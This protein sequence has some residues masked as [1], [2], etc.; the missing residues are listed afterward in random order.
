MG[1]QES[2]EEKVISEALNKAGKVNPY[3]KVANIA[4]KVTG[5]KVAEVGARAIPKVPNMP[6]SFLDNNKIKDLEKDELEKQDELENQDGLENQQNNSRYDLKSMFKNRLKSKFSKGKNKTEEENGLSDAINKFK[7]AERIGTI[8]LSITPILLGVF[9]TIIVVIIVLSPLFH[10]KEFKSNTK[11]KFVNF[12]TF[13]GFVT[14]QELIDEFYNEINS[15]SLNAQDKFMVDIDEELLEATLLYG[16]YDI[17]DYFNLLNKYETNNGV[18]SDEEGINYK[19]LTKEVYFTSRNMMY[20]SSSITNEI[21]KEIV[22][23]ENASIQENSVD[24]KED[25][26]KEKEEKYILRCKYGTE[27]S[28][29]D[30]ETYKTISDSF[31]DNRVTNGDPELY[32][33]N[34]VCLSTLYTYDESKYEKFLKYIYIPYKKYDV[35]IGGATTQYNK[36][37]WEGYSEELYSTYDP[38]EIGL[39]Y[40]GYDGLTDKQKKNVDQ[41]VENIKQYLTAQNEYY[42]SFVKS[43]PGNVSM[44]VALGVGENIIITSNFGLRMHPIYGDLRMHTGVDIVCSTK[45]GP[46]YAV[47]DGTV[48]YAGGNPISGYGYYVKIGHDTNFDN[49]YDYYTLYAHLSTYTVHI[50][51]NVMNGQQ[52]G[53]M[54]STG[55]STGP[56]LHFEIRNYD[57]KSNQENYVDPKPY[58]EDIYA[59]VNNRQNN[60]TVTLAS[61][62]NS[63]LSE[64]EINRLTSEL[65]ATVD[66]AGLKSRESA[67]AAAKFLSSNLAGLPYF[68]GGYTSSAIDINWY[69]SKKVTA[70]TEGRIK[71]QTKGNYYPYGMDCS[72]FVSW[73]LNNAGYKVGYKVSSELG[74]LGQKVKLN[75]SR[76]KVGDLV[77]T[78]GHIGII[79]G[80]D[81]NNMIVAHEN[82][83]KTGL[84]TSTY[85]RNLQERFTNAVLMDDF[86]RNI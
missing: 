24:V 31:I 23:D 85:S 63:K 13:K 58:L 69:T 45:Y 46:I 11:E 1:K 79:I 77:W 84:T 74:N 54:G 21:V 41:T 32:N 68:W 62:T 51:D 37:N 47:A 53:N 34:F 15:A 9:T 76:V 70:E 16:T 61:N 19:K 56:H 12:F 14:N 86:Y 57:A 10:F 42:G 4:N 28:E 49:V 20:L 48:V 71:T 18:L 75:D 38:K 64:D 80:L 27:I 65:K 60:S 6:T 59:R 66:S 67:I 35:K 83:V 5:G 8:L 36:S 52:I 50:G 39:G 29:R 17:E 82:G 2:V 26:D 73:V 25:T 55:A 81:S 44:P 78:N 43:I 7:N 33:D 22:E 30:I 72:G 40:N 3:A